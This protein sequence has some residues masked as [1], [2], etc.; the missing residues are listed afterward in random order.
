MK[1]LTITALFALLMPFMSFAQGPFDGTWRL[2]RADVEVVNGKDVSFSLGDG[3]YRCDSCVVKYEVKADG[4]D[5]EISGGANR[6]TMNIRVTSDKAIEITNKK[7][8]AVVGTEIRTVSPDGKA[9]TID[10]TAVAPTGQSS[11]GRMIFSRIAGPANGTHAISGTW[12]PEKMEVGPEIT[13]MG[14]KVTADTL[15]MSDSLGNSYAAKFD[16][17]DYPFQGD[18]GIT[19]VSLQKIAENTVE[20]TDWRDGRVVAVVRLTVA[21]DRQTMSVLVTD[22]ITNTTSRALWRKQ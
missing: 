21:D 16:G 8:G 11:K 15:S 4:E 7:T 17:D 2:N 14:I 22:K 9:L 6:D 18:P 12:H 13:T 5:H 3:I 1:K 19:T 10:W 20:E